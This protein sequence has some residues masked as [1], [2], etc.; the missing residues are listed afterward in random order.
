MRISKA[1]VVASWRRPVHCLSAVLWLSP[2]FG[3]SAQITHVQGSSGDE[4]KAT[5]TQD[6]KALP[7]LMGIHD[8]KQQQHTQ[9]ETETK[10][11]AGIYACRVAPLASPRNMPRMPS[12]Q[13]LDGGAWH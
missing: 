2:A 12:W 6:S 5:I 1:G 7:P 13:G 9:R 10:A 11:E 4:I 3:W 8:A